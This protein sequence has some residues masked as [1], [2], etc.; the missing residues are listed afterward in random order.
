M[1]AAIATAARPTATRI[2]GVFRNF[3][4]P[5]TKVTDVDQPGRPGSCHFNSDLGNVAK[6][7]EIFFPRIIKGILT[8]KNHKKIAFHVLSNYIHTNN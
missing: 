4:T 2:P 6:T 5:E 3:K 8:N 1:R 7:M